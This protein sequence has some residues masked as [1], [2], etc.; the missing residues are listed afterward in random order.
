MTADAPINRFTDLNGKKI[1]VIK[2]TTTE[3]RL[4]AAMKARLVNAQV[5]AINDGTAKP[6]SDYWQF[7]RLRFQLRHAKTIRD[8]GK[9]ED[10]RLAII[11]GLHVCR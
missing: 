10:V 4:N 2:G 1:A 11:A 9:N 5:I 6:R 3:Q 7:P 8:C